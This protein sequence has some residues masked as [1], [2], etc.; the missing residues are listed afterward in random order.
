MLL[1]LYRLLEEKNTDEEQVDAKRDG[2]MLAAMVPC[3]F[4]FPAPVY[5]I[6]HHD[7]EGIYFLQDGI[8]IL[9]G[10]QVA[11]IAV[12]E[13]EV[14]GRQLAQ[15]ILQHLVEVSRHGLD[16]KQAHFLKIL[17]RDLMD[18][19]IA[20][21]GDYPCGRVGQCK[22]GGRDAEG[23]AE[24]Q[25]GR[26]PGSLYDAIQQ[27]SIL[28]GLRCILRNGRDASPF[29][30]RYPRS[31]TQIIY[32][33][34]SPVVDQLPAKLLHR[35]VVGIDCSIIQYADD[36]IEDEGRMD[37]MSLS[38]GGLSPIIK[39]FSNELRPRIHV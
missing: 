15:D 2:W 23:S 18:Q 6:H 35:F 14:D 3:L 24:L 21:D 10:W 17:F 4:H 39:I 12:D 28:T 37:T 20:F 16:I 29:F 25:Y 36:E 5:I 27:L 19:F 38:I 7:G 9:D 8:E 26:W 22:I 1:L 33:N 31:C 11:V 30:F 13:G 32:F 34:R